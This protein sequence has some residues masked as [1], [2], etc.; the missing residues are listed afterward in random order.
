VDIPLYFDVLLVMI[1]KHGTLP[2]IINAV[3]MEITGLSQLKEKS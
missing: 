2:P 1:L 3:T